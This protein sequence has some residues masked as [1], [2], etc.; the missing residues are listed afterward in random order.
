MAITAHCDTAITSLGLAPRADV[1]PSCGHW[2]NRASLSAPTRSARPGA[3]AGTACRCLPAG[4]ACSLTI[5]LP[6]LPSPGASR[7]QAAAGVAAAASGV[8]AAAAHGRLRNSRELGFP[9]VI[10][11]L[12]TQGLHWDRGNF[13]PL[14]AGLPITPLDQCTP[15]P[16]GKGNPPFLCQPLHNPGLSWPHC[17]PLSIPISRRLPQRQP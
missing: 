4:F 8:A 7:S 10:P 13:R 16:H 5:R 15:R 12:T 3:T 6:Q 11:V 1:G 17:Q 14:P 2:A 9:R